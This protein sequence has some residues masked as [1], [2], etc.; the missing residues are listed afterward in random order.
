MRCCV[1][2]CHVAFW[3]IMFCPRMSC[4]ILAYHVVSYDVMLHSGMS[5]LVLGC[6]VAFWDVV[7]CPGMSCC[8]LGCCVVCPYLSA[9]TGKVS[10]FR[11]W[12]MW[13]FTVDWCGKNGEIYFPQQTRKTVYTLDSILHEKVLLSK[14]C[15][16]CFRKSIHSIMFLKESVYF[17]ALRVFNV[18]IRQRPVFECLLFFQL[19]SHFCYNI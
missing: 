5:C 17:S 12:L 7:L 2:G 9:T 6:H 15:T 4:C 11:Q 8:I 1:L 14:T 13:M 16:F 19:L 18:L 10:F 3:D